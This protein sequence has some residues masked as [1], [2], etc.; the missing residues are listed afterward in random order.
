M[1]PKS[2]V[3]LG[4]AVTMMVSSF[5]LSGKGVIE[6][7]ESFRGWLALNLPEHIAGLKPPAR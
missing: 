2:S 4:M 6:H 7:S 3:I 5:E 1:L